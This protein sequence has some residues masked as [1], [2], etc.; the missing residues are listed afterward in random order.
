MILRLLFCLCLCPFAT[1][2]QTTPPARATQHEAARW[3]AD[4]RVSRPEFD[5]ASLRYTES[6][7]EG[8]ARTQRVSRE[9]LTSLMRRSVSSGSPQTT[10]NRRA[11]VALFERY[12]AQT[13]AASRLKAERVLADFKQTLTAEGMALP[14]NQRIE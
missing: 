1:E 7:S 13:D 5:R 8:D 12:A 14:E 11:L 2:A 10:K 6:L 3:T 9:A 4:Q